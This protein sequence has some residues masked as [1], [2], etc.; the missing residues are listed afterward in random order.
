MDILY[1]AENIILDSKGRHVREGD[2]LLLTMINGDRVVGI[3]Q[4]P[5]DPNCKQYTI[6]VLEDLEACAIATIVYY[7]CCE[8]NFDLLIQHMTATGFQLVD[9]IVVPL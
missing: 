9:G 6:R 7:S 5:F 1:T 8:A 4:P 2:S 3:M